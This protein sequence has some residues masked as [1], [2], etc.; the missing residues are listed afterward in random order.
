MNSAN[1]HHWPA[2]LGQEFHDLQELSLNVDILTGELLGSWGNLGYW[3]RDDG[4][5]IDHYSEAAQQ[6]AQQLA[7][8]TQLQPQHSV[9]DVGFGCGDQLI[10]WQRSFQIEPIWGM[11]LSSIQTEYAHEKLALFNCPARIHQGDACDALAWETLPTSF[12]RIIA[13]DCVYHFSNKSVFLD[14]C[15]VYL[16]NST[17]SLDKN[18]LIVS[19]FI[20]QNPVNSFIHTL[21]LRVICFF[22]H[23]PFNNLKTRREYE[24]ELAQAGLCLAEYKDVSAAVMLPF[25][26]WIMKNKKA[27]NNIPKN[28]L[29]LFSKKSSSKY[30]G[31][32]LFLRW[33][34]RHKI[35]HYALMRIQVNG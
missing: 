12:N 22:S 20:L 27:T 32:A 2:N 6:L 7:I 10:Y 23:I 34:A 29:G 1:T 14:L 5:V 3:Y 26:D 31:T 24:L 18:E 33:A 13:L 9:L 16:K 35:F 15:F 21:M 30:I 25:S 28:H 4:S 17:P 11:N 8:F 19:D